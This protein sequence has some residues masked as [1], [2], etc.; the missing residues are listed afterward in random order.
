MTSHDEWA[1]F[2][3]KDA[4]CKKKRLNDCPEAPSTFDATL[5]RWSAEMLARAL[6]TFDSY[7][8]VTTTFRQNAYKSE[9]CTCSSGKELRA[10]LSTSGSATRLRTKFDIPSVARFENGKRLEDSEVANRAHCEG[11]DAT[12]L[13]N[14]TWKN[15]NSTFARSHAH[16]SVL[17]YT[18]RALANEQ[19]HFFLVHTLIER[20][21][22]SAMSLKKQ[23][24]QKNAHIQTKYSSCFFLYL[25]ISSDSLWYCV[26]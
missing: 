25:P 17:E 7:N 11:I 26:L 5:K 23:G 3:L 4:S 12:S 2:P 14:T 18:E 19:T 22:K 6:T 9:R 20:K 10:L 15:A 8:E 1:R 21:R 16:M 13:I 24:R